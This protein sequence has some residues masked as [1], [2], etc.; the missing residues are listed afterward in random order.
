MEFAPTGKPDFAKGKGTPGIVK[1]FVDGTEI[2]RGDL[3]NDTQ[4]G[5]H[6]AARCLSAPILARR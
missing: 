2:G 4:T 3:R 6:K 5:W 1:L